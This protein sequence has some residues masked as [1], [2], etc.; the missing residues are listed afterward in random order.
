MRKDTSRWAAFS[1]VLFLSFGVLALTTSHVRAQSSAIVPPPYDPFELVTS[2]PKAASVPRLAEALLR[3]T[4]KRRTFEGAGVPYTASISFDASGFVQ[5]VGAGE[6]EETR[7]A[8]GARRWMGH[9]GNYSLLRIITRGVFDEGTPGPIPMRLMMAREYALGVVLDSGKFIR[10]AEATFN[11]TP[12]TCILIS[13]RRVVTPARDWS[14]AEYCVD[15]K[16]ELL[17]VYSAAPGIY[18]SY[19]YSSTSFHGRVVPNQIT[20]AEAG[21][22]VLQGNIS[23]RDPNSLDPALFTPTRQMITGGIQL[24]WPIRHSLPAAPNTASN[25]LQPIV[26]HATVAPDG[27]VIEAEA[28]Q[29]ADLGLSLAAVDLVKKTNYQD[30]VHFGY[31][32]ELEV[33]V[34]VQ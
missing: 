31:P 19:E 5:D 8:A 2:Q 12:V 28:L 1:R 25:L 3:R 18:V 6:M 23:V 11:G 34:T 33:F 20:I 7:N 9:L 26:V 17:D 13:N 30:P 22:V 10:T 16:S 14:E 24:T 32:A 15:P 21:E 4:L 29:N 27:S